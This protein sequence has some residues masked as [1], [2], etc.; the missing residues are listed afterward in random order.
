MLVR[1]QNHSIAA[2][3]SIHFLILFC[4]HLRGANDIFFS[5]QSIEDIIIKE[6][7]LLCFCFTS[8]IIFQSENDEVS[9][10][11]RDG[12]DGRRRMG[13]DG[14]NESFFS[15]SF[16]CLELINF[17][18]KRILL[19]SYFSSSIK[20]REVLLLMSTYL[21]CGR[22]KERKGN[23]KGKPNLAGLQPGKKARVGCF[24]FYC[25]NEQKKFPTRG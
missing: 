16:A 18:L 1:L 3:R 5:F 6:R 17:N 22:G 15:L 2:F 9:S 19:S 20:K 14:K 11:N 7:A 25:L 10:L 21:S 8:L 24:T 23:T 13:W 4:S 12:K